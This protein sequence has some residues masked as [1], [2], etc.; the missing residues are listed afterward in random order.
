MNLTKH[1]TLEEFLNSETAKKKGIR[2]VPNEAEI[3]WML[4][5]A[6]HVLE[7]L[8]EKL[9]RAVV[10]TSGYR[11]RELNKFVGG[12]PNSQH[13]LGQAADI[14]AT[15]DEQRVICDIL[16]ENPYI[17]QCI[18]ERTKNASWIHVSWGPR[19]RK[20]FLAIKK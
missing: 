15:A 18:I 3:D 4:F 1:F 8:R 6:I 12:V 13:C 2:N 20:Q 11:S 10:I 17:D 19:N 7:F 9:N 14:R 16:R 5:G